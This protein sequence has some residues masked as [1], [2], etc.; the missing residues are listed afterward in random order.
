MP[1]CLAHPSGRYVVI[2]LIARAKTYLH[3]K[4]VGLSEYISGDTA[5]TVSRHDVLQADFPGSLVS[6][7]SELLALTLSHTVSLHIPLIALEYLGSFREAGFHTTCMA[8][9]SMQAASD[10]VASAKFYTGCKDRLLQPVY[11]LPWISRCMELMLGGPVSM[12]CYK[13][14]VL[15]GYKLHMQGG[16][17]AKQKPSR[18][19]KG[20]PLQRAYLESN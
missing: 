18:Y 1:C 10:P 9:M 7:H 5:T 3:S 15:P 6:F 17:A 14:C 4:W 20:L 12:S 16:A 11:K 19:G 2:V 13:H 8:L